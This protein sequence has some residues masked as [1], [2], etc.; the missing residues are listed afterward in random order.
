MSGGGSDSRQVSVVGVRENGWQLLTTASAIGRSFDFDTLREA[1]GRSEEETVTALEE[2]IGQGLVTEVRSAA[3]DQSLIYDFNHE[4]LRALVYEQ[5]SIARRRLLHRRIAEVFASRTRGYRDS[6]TIVGQIAHHYQ[7]AGNDSLA[8]EYYRLAGER[9]RGLYANTEALAH[10]R[11]ALALGHPETAALHE[12]IGDL[13]TLLGEYGAALKSYET[14][15]ALGDAEDLGKI[16]YK[17]GTIYER[18]RQWELAESHFEAP[19]PAID[20]TRQAGERARGRATWSWTAHHQGRLGK[21]LELAQQALD[22]A[23]A[24]RDAR[25]LAQ[26]HSILGILASRQGNL[27]LAH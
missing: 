13:H 26:A 10:L 14:A 23:E 15:A 17:L 19:L 9:A 21:S 11:L 3:G 8:A 24:A 6:A 27:A 4:K 18:R 25:A 1:S 12:A 20:D 7:M 2:L 22:L 16:E 5:A